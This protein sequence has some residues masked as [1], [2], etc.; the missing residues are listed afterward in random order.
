LRSVGVVAGM[1]VLH[2]LAHVRLGVLGKVVEHV[3]F[4]VDVA[5]LGARSRRTRA[6]PRAR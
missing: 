5:S 6:S 2:H 1:R 4:L 3:A